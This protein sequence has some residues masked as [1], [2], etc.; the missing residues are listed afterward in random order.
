LALCGVLGSAQGASA[1]GTPVQGTPEQGASPQGAG[2]AA[3]DATAEPPGFLAGKVIDAETGKGLPFTNISFLKITATEPAGAAAGGINSKL[4]GSFLAPVAP[5]RYTLVCRYVSYEQLEIADVVVRAGETT[6]VD[7]RLNAA[8]IQTKAIVVQ[9]DRMTN[10]ENTVLENKRKAEAI[11]DGISGEQISRSTDSNAAEAVGRVTG[12]S[13][14]D[15]KYVY[16]RGLGERYSSAQ[17]N[18]SSVGSP[19]ANKRVLPLDI[20]ASGMLDNITIQKTFTPDMDG[21]FGG[22]VVNINTKEFQDRRVLTQSASFGVK[23]GAMSGRFLTYNGGTLDFLG[24]DD[25]TRALPDAV[26]RLAGDQAVNRTDFPV[27]ELAEMG[28]SFKN[29]WTPRRT[30]A[31]PSFS[32]ATLYSDKF[33]LFDRDLGFLFS[34]SL[35]NGFRSADRE[36]NV[37]EGSTTPTPRSL[38]SVED[39]KASVLA[40][41]T[42]SMTYRFSDKHKLKGSVVLSKDSE[43][44]ARISAG[45][46]EDYGTA[47]LQQTTLAFI[48][49][50]L[51]S[52]VFNGNHEMTRSSIDWTF[53]YSRAKHED[54]DRRLSIYEENAATGQLALSRR[55]VHPLTRIFGESTERDVAFK[56][57]WLVPVAEW[58]HVDTRFKWGLAGRFRDRESGY[59]RFG[60]YARF[61]KD[62]DRTREP[63]DILNSEALDNGDWRL[64][65]LTRANDAWFATH[66]QSATYGMLDIGFFDR[67]RLVGGARFEQSIQ[68]VE[69]RSPFVNGDPTLVGLE[70]DDVLPAANLTWNMTSRMNLRLAWSET[71]ARPE[72]RELS[73]FSMYNYEEGYEEKGNVELVPARLHNYDVRWE[74]FPGRGEYVGLSFF[75]K[76][77]EHPLEKLLSPSTGG[78]ALEPLNGESG[79]LTGAEVELRAGLRRF[80]QVFGGT[81]GM[82]WDR[83]GVS[84][85]YSRV[86]SKV[87]FLRND[88]V[89]ETPLNGQASHTWNAGLFFKSARLDGT[90]M[91]RSSGERLSAFGLGVLPDVYEQPL[92][93]LSLTLGLRLNSS[94][95]MKLQA[96]NLFDEDVVFHQGPLITKRY[97]PGRAISVSLKYN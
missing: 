54:L 58:T 80:R 10:T 56:V 1:Q 37:Y 61:G 30:G 40:G 12:V 70:G 24:F 8:P 49:R 31:Q 65:E 75:H 67:F 4:D 57:N 19:E 3:R 71:L 92:T 14:V 43:D 15:G 36:E 25:G 64:E 72:L 11:T 26:H 93:D 29:E 6:A 38:Y 89:Y 21:E 77:F 59:R 79:K 63:E 44:R 5:G 78:Y 2:S 41:I 90:L 81:P 39:S 66:L 55:F 34:F 60:F 88:T 35:S 96:E 28:K 95:R 83:W 74:A 51:I 18:G 20:F 46:N 17:L 53:S 69:A 91:Y 97:L 87:E 13:V 45:P 62:G 76:D 50:S 68:E 86:D 42:S 33:S 82:G 84:V 16:V 9:A 27:P 22:G 73:P 32:Y 7:A 48:E 23:Q 47:N 85:N 94:L 52:T